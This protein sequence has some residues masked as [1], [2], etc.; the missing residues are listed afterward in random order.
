MRSPV[1]TARSASDC[2]FR[3]SLG[4]SD[5]PLQAAWSPALLSPNPRST[6]TAPDCSLL[7]QP[8]SA[9]A[10]AKSEHIQAL[11]FV[12]IP[13]AWV[14]TTGLPVTRLLVHG[15]RSVSGAPQPDRFDNL[16]EVRD[17]L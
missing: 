8:D 14:S 12:A 15:T 7:Y 10:Q 2:F 3:R 17:P 1:Q 5:T 13:S 11:G 4:L 6:G 9:D 16:Q